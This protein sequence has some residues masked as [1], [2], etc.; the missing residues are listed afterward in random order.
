MPAAAAAAAAA[1]AATFSL[2]TARSRWPSHTYCRH[3]HRPP[4]CRAGGLL[5]PLALMEADREAVLVANSWH[6]R[7]RRRGSTEL[8]GC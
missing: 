8:K 3:C 4:P 2:P 6:R 5:Q 7:T 1:T